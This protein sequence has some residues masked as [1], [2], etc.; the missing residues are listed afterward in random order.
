MRTSIAVAV[1]FVVLEL[2]IV[3][4]ASGTTALLDQVGILLIVDG[5]D[6]DN[7]PLN[8]PITSP[9]DIA[10]DPTS[11]D[12][13]LLTGS[14][15]FRKA[16]SSSAFVNTN[17]LSANGYE[18][19]AVSPDGTIGIMD[20]S[21]FLLIEGT[22]GQSITNLAPSLTSP[23][24]VA[25][26]PT[27]GQL[28]LLT[29]AGLFTH[30]PYSASFDNTNLLPQSN[31]YEEIS[32]SAQGGI[33]ILD[34]SGFLF[35]DDSMGQVVTTLDSSIQSSQD[36]A[37]DPFGGDVLVLAGSGVFSHTPHTSSFTDTGVLSNNNGFESIATLVPEP[38]SLMLCSITFVTILLL[39]IR[40]CRPGVG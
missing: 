24:D 38:S 19:I 36:I 32:I 21:G 3:T 1:S 5:S 13:V 17:I 29:G 35:V 8:S 31:G 25:F 10:F 34:T 20:T 7:I 14:G 16:P 40:R 12:L 22:S 11:G 28:L 39:G 23:Q 30:V 26:D 18:A 4:S 37:H 33:A 9:Q 2:T 15:V 6:Q 27:T